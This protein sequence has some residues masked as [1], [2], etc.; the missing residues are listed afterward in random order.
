MKLFL[1]I[2]SFFSFLQCSSGFDYYSVRKG[3]HLSEAKMSSVNEFFERRMKNTIKKIIGNNWEILFEEE[4]RI[5]YGYPRV[6]LFI[7]SVYLEEFYFV[8][9]SELAAQFPLYKTFDGI[10]MRK[11]VYQSVLEYKKLKS[12]QISQSLKHTPVL[13]DNAMEVKVNWRYRIDGKPEEYYDVLL[14]EFDKNTLNLVSV[15]KLN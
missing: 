14:F 13:K 15:K 5:Y 7:D 11:L 9:K 2:L 1:S 10:G 12:H 3:E 4:N 8:D 6:K